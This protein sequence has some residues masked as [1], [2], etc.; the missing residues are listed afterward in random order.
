MLSRVEALLRGRRMNWKIA[1]AK[2]RFSEVVREAAEG[3]QLIYNRDRLV[4]VIV[5]AGEYGDF[6]AWKEKGKAPS[7]AEAIAEIRRICA[8]EGY[9][10]EVPERRD[11]TN[12]FATA[13]DEVPL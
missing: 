11:R 3:P 7:M 6:E 9:D 2:Q 12:D 8:Q 5:D 10:L 13:L 1:E 4:A